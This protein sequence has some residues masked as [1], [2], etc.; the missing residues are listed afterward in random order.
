MSKLPVLES[1]AVSAPLGVVS[2]FAGALASGITLKSN[3][4]TS[5]THISARNVDFDNREALLWDGDFLPFLVDLELTSEENQDLYAIIKDNIDVFLSS[6]QSRTRLA[7]TGASHGGTRVVKPLRRLR[8]D[9]LS[10][11]R[12]EELWYSVAWDVRRSGEL[13]LPLEQDVWP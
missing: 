6:L 13:C 8:I 11:E 1:L 4:F 12:M 7:S 5:L 9:G 3:Q 2:A 10:D